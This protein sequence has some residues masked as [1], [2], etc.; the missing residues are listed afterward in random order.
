MDRNACTHG[1]PIHEG[2]IALLIFIEYVEAMH[3]GRVNSGM[4][5]GVVPEVIDSLYEGID[6]WNHGAN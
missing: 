2:L 6:V 1:N 4:F 3:S 5:G